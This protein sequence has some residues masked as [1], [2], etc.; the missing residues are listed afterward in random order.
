MSRRPTGRRDASDPQQSI[1]DNHTAPHHQDASSLLIKRVNLSLRTRATCVTT[2]CAL[3][4]RQADATTAECSSGWRKNT[5]PPG[6]PFLLPLG[7]RPTLSPEATGPGRC[8][9]LPLHGEAPGV[10]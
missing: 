4:R 6:A 1:K 9:R 10:K 3:A 7:Y 5:L 8:Q 2:C